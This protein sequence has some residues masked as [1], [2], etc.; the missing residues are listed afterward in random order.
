MSFAGIII[1]DGKYKEYINLTLGFILIII[2]IRPI[3]AVVAGLSDP[4]SFMADAAYLLDKGYF[5]NTVGGDFDDLQMEMIVSEYKNGLSERLRAVINKETAKTGL[6]YLSSEFTVDTSEEGLGGILRVDAVVVNSK[7]VAEE[8]KKP[9]IRVERVEIDMSIPFENINKSDR[10]E[11]DN[12][13]TDADNEEIINLKNKI[14]D[15]Y[16][17]PADNINIRVQDN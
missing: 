8:T 12:K 10:D 15:F 3:G 7:T 17:L 9:F 14:S 11:P 2:M 16:N 6:T 5:I 13:D 1:P 4:D